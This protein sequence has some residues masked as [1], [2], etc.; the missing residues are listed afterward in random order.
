MFISI[1]LFILLDSKVVT[2][3]SS[4][5]FVLLLLLLAFD[6]FTK[7]LAGDLTHCFS[8]ILLTFYNQGS[9]QINVFIIK[10]P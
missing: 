5:K 1:A 7:S 9:V 6:F 4:G 8:V 3:L 10:D 2:I